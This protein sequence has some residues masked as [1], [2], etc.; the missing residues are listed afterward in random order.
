[1]I[2][3]HTENRTP[4]IEVTKKF[5]GAGEWQGPPLFKQFYFQVDQTEAET[6]SSDWL[7]DLLVIIIYAL[8]L[9]IVS[10]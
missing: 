10:A 2:K 3:D 5:E 1:M 8:A 6:F 9:G 7:I 4:Y